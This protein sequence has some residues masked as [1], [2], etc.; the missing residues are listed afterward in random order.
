MRSQLGT[1]K[2]IKPGIWRVAV[3]RGYNAH[4]SARRVSE[5]VYGT[6]TDADRA[7]VR[8]ASDMGRCLTLGDP[9]T[10]DTYFWSIFLPER[11]RNTTKANANTYASIYRKHIS[12]FFGER[13][14]ASI[15]NL[16]VKDWIA[17]LPPQSAPAY[18]RA[19]R[20][21]FNAADFA[22]LLLDNPMGSG[23]RFSMPRG[24]RKRP[25]AVWGPY[26]VGRCINLMRGNRL[27]AL[28]LLMVGG[29]LSR[30]E[31]LARDWEEITWTQVLNL[32]NDQVQWTAFIPVDSAYTD[33]DGLKDPKNDLRYRNVPLRPVFANP[34]HDCIGSGPICQSIKNGKLTGH[35]LT[36]SYVPKI[37]RT[38]FET[39]G[40]LE[41]LPFVKLNRMRATYSTMMQQA[42]IDATIINAIQGRSEN[43]KVL[44][45]NYLSPGNETF[46]RAADSM[47]DLIQE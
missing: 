15:T 11:Q 34:L 32:E 25:I 37:W 31:A 21:I 28:W 26:E 1:K 24:Q 9:M 27:Y 20:A 46:I 4:G 38:L 16:E 29:G 47:G 41:T 43:S 40:C 35:R 39:G 30:S 2:E 5:T 36:P 42:G 18:T 6:S 44:Y 33:T 7:I 22:H 14:I 17:D 10:L 45:S 8:I 3:A 19:A 23:Y 13:E 12:P